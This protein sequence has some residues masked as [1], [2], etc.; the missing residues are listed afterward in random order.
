[1]GVGLLSQRA[2]A[3]PEEA[4]FDLIDHLATLTTA[5]MKLFRPFGRY[6]S[7]IN[8]CASPK[9][10]NRLSINRE[11]LST[12]DPKMTLQP[13]KKLAAVCGLF[14]PACTY[15]IGSTADS[16]RLKRLAERSGHT[17]EEIECHGCRSDK[18]TLYCD[19]QNGQCAAEG[20]TSAGSA[21]ISCRPPG[22]PGRPASPLGI[23]GRPGA[24]SK[25]GMNS[26][27]PKWGSIMPVTARLNSAYD[28]AC[29]NCGANPGTYVAGTRMRFCSS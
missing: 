12:G 8:G 15:Y 27:S 9:S 1:M 5:A 17:V 18:V 3:T 22:V 28:L 7:K 24:D 13:D 21:P 23:M 4:E 6:I 2:E 20:W 29:R 19:L 11:I 16:D 14:C 26:G 10:G 25:A